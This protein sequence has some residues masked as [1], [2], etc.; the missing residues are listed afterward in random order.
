MLKF[1]ENLSK[2][3]NRKKRKKTLLYSLFFFICEKPYVE[4]ITTNMREE[5]QKLMS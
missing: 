4:F 1:D 5:K 2:E 3:K